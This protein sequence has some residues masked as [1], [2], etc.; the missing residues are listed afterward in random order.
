MLE[1]IKKPLHFSLRTTLL[2]VGTNMIGGGSTDGFIEIEYPSK[3]NDFIVG[4]HGH[5]AINEDLSNV[6]LMK[7]H[8]L[9][10]TREYQILGELL[11]LH[12][13]ATRKPTFPVLMKDLNN[14]DEISEPF[15]SFLDRPTMNKDG[16]NHNRTFELLLPNGKAN[17]KFGAFNS[18]P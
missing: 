16:Q 10:S 17:Q 13:R 2:T 5:V 6:I 3:D 1:T 12:R 18:L 14:G 8:V 15:G 4:R 11:Q 7:V 9:A